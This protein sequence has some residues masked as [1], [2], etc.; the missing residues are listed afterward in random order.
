MPNISVIFESFNS[1]K[2]NIFLK[3]ISDLEVDSVNIYLKDKNNRL[4]NTDFEQILLFS[5]PLSFF[6][7]GNNK[8]SKE[9]I[10]KKGFKRFELFKLSENFEQ[11]THSMLPEKLMV[12]YKHFFEAFNYHNYFNKK[13]YIDNRGFIKNGLSNKKK[14]DNI[15][16]INKDELIKII[17]S[18]Q[19]QYLWNVKKQNTLVCKDCEFRFMCV[20]PRVP[21]ENANGDW[22][23]E[24]ECNYNPYI[25]KWHNEDNFIKLSDSGVNISKTGKIN[26]NKKKVKE[27]FQKNWK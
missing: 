11:Y 27:A 7:F 1:R 5:Q 3:N 18:R 14:F 22:Y 9:V 4:S 8:F 20:D 23:H 10:K 25:S 16:R 13:L 26:I 17:D 6:T 12:N 15:D 21:K 2:I 19:F 24:V